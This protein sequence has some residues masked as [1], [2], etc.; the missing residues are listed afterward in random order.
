MLTHVEELKKAGEWD[1]VIRI[2]GINLNRLLR[3]TPKEFRS[4][5]EIGFLAQLAEGRPTGP[6]WM[7]Y[8]KMMLI[9][10]LKYTGDIATAKGTEKDGF[11]W[12]LKALHLLLDVLAKDELMESVWAPSLEELLAAL[13]PFSLPLETRLLLMKEFEREGEFGKV[14]DQYEAALKE[15]PEN[16]RIQEI[17]QITFE[18]IAQ[19]NDATLKRAGLPRAKIDELLSELNSEPFTQSRQDAEQSHCCHCK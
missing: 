9:A 17:G 7:P 11:T 5:T 19:Q 3:V 16:S 2:V 4:L 15:S 13:E 1:A 6:V 12:Y 18:R 8:K 14:R 10:L